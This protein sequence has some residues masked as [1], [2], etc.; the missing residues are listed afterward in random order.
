MIYFLPFSPQKRLRQ[1]DQF[2][3]QHRQI[4]LHLMFGEK[5][6]H[7]RHGNLQRLLQGIAINT[8][9][10]QRKGNGTK[11][12]LCRQSKGGTIAAAQKHGLSRLSPAPNGAHRVDH[13]LRWQCKPFCHHCLSCGTASQLPAGTRHLRIPCCGKNRTADPS[14]RG[15]GGIGRIDNDIHMHRG[16]VLFYNR[17]W[18]TNCP[19]SL[20]FLRPSIPACLYKVN[21]KAADGAFFRRRLLNY[22]VFGRFPR[23]KLPHPRPPSPEDCPK[24]KR[25]APNFCLRPPPK[26]HSV[27][28][29]L[30]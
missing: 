17:K 22:A 26:R 14:S 20:V 16:N 6:L 28:R 30:S 8:G 4:N 25:D 15:Q 18:H 5:C 29:R 21:E 1:W 24:C 2:L 13:R 12:R 27:R 11:A 9:G 23:Q 19:L 7:R 10:N 3:L